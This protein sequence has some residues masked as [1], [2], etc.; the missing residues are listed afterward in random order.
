VAKA[1]YVAKQARP[2]IAVSVAFLTT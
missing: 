1:L 2:N